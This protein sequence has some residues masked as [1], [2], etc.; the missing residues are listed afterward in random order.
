[1][2]LGDRTSQQILINFSQGARLTMNQILSA[3]VY[4]PIE[5]IIVI[6]KKI[7]L[8]LDIRTNESYPKDLWNLTFFSLI[9][10]FII[11]TSL[12]FT[13]NKL[14]T[15]KEKT[16]GV[17]LFV[18]A[19]LPQTIMNVEW[20]YYIILYLMIYYIFVFK[21]VSLVEQKEKFSELKKEGYFKFIS[22]AIVMFFVISSYYLH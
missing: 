19:I 15:K 9:N 1:M 11:A 20:R 22:F 14:F 13:K 16:L 17:M 7:F 18:S 21:F 8:A 5:T 3:F 4:S 2:G 6:V 12:F 10:Y